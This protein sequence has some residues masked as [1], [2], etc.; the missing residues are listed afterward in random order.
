MQKSLR[1]A[2]DGSFFTQR[3]SGIQRFAVEL[4]AALDEQLPPDTLCIV[5]PQGTQT[6]AY[7]NLR[8]VQ[9]GAPGPRWEQW[10]Y[11]RYLAKHRLRWLCLCNV[12]PL[13]APRRCNGIAVLHDVCY[14]ARPDFYTD[15]R[16]RASAAWHK[17]H[18]RAIVRR[19]E[20]IV[21]VSE[22]SKSEIVRYYHADAARIHVVYNAWQQ[23]QR[24]SQDDTVF[25]RHPALQP[26]EYYFSMANL[27]KNKNFPWVLRAAAAKP[28][29][30]FAIAG[31]GSLAEQAAQLGLA[32]LPNVHYLGYVTDEEARALMAHCK[33]FLFPTLY[34]GFGI[35]PLEAIA[36]GAPQVYV[37]DTPCMR[38]VYGDCAGY[39]DLATNPGNVDDIAPPKAPA[40]QLLQ[41][42]SWQESAR[43]L[44]ALL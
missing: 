15:P 20:K 7:R 8:V 29:A 18:Y 37:S 24:V 34:E 10:D 2:V 5:V 35:P 36:C 1:Y 11:P 26:G 33:A 30:Q 22:F 25:Q 17:L 4:L 3:L 38:E 42:Y 40:A 13:A 31:G 14:R 44:A 27:L 16:G 41:R 6:P 9:Y 23:M 39:I 21:T 12:I 28:Q 32:D 43:R 19:A